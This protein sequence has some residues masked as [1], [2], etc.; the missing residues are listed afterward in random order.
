MTKISK[1]LS[2]AAIGIALGATGVALAH[3]TGGQGVMTP[4]AGPM[5][6]GMTT[7]N[8]AAIHQKMT[9][10]GMGAGMMGGGMGAGMMGGGMGHGMMMGY[11]AP[12]HQ[13]QTVD[14]NLSGE[15]VQKI[16]TGHLT[17]MGHKRLQVGEVKKQ[18]NGTLL[19]DI[20]TL[21]G[22]LVMRMEVDPKTGAM[23]P[24]NE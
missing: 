19:A 4:G 24:V 7:P 9:G 1:I 17:L 22:S 16:L 10:G 15:D 8:H 23:H 12:H 6:Q 18:E 14:R 3:G 20:N 2:V 11:T 13:D 5:G 21:D